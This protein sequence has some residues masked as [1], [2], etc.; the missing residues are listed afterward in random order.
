MGSALSPQDAD[1]PRGHIQARR[2]HPMLNNLLHLLV[3]FVVPM[4]LYVLLVIMDLNAVSD[5]MGMLLMTCQF[6]HMP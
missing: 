2:P 5:N 3:L 6:Q 1:S 4:V